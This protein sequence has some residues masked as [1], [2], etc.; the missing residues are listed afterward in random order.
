MSTNSSIDGGSLLRS[1]LRDRSTFRKP[2]DKKKKSSNITESLGTLIVAEKVQKEIKAR[3]NIIKDENKDMY[4]KIYKMLKPIRVAMI[5]S[6]CLLIFFTKPRWCEIRHDLSDDCNF[7]LQGAEYY[8]N[9]LPKL[10][11]FMG[12]FLEVF[13]MLFIICTYRLK[14]AFHKDK[15]QRAYKF[16]VQIVIMCLSI[17]TF[18]TRQ[19]L[20]PTHFH[21]ICFLTFV[22]YRT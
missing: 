6:C 18:L 22:M 7:D 8:I 5:Y 21:S 16:K 1:N 2:S 9:D 11:S 17:L 10:P 3:K 4:K 12:F 20:P 14:T 19:W 13:T 15:E